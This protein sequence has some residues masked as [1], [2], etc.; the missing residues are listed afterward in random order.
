MN[1]ESS[2]GALPPTGM[3]VFGGSLDWGMKPRI[4]LY[5]E[6]PALYNAINWSISWNVGNGV[7]KTVYGATVNTF[8]CPSDG[9]MTNY[10]RYGVITAMSSYGN[11]LGICRTLNGGNFDG[12]AYTVEGVYGPVVT[13]A[14]ITDGTSN[15]AMHSEWIRGKGT[16]P[17]QPGPQAVYKSSIPF[18]QN[19][20]PTFQGNSIATTIQYYTSQCTTAMGPTWDMK[21][22]AWVDG[23]SLSGGGYSHM[24]PPNK[25]ACAFSTD[26][27]APFPDRT[28][29]GPSSNHPGG[30]NMG[31]LDGSVKF[32]KNSINLT[33]W[34]AIA[35]KAGAEVI[36]ASSL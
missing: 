13:L 31:F 34:G 22:Y 15:T 2:N 6:Q 1:Y 12:P 33:T 9:N 27:S 29:G 10:S 21:G 8:L 32:I 30:V 3:H 36:D 14:S 7:N 11:N 18:T 16:N 24:S 5:M 28:M 19:T 23:W 26:G 4:L 35:T 25:L 20:S 17:A